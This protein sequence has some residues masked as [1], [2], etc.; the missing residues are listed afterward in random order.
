MFSPAFA[1]SFPISVYHRELMSNAGLVLVVDSILRTELAPRDS[2]MNFT[3][4]VVF[5]EGK[6]VETEYWRKHFVIWEKKNHTIVSIKLTGFLEIVASFKW[7]LDYSL[8]TLG[9]GH[10]KCEIL[11]CSACVFSI[12]QG[13]TISV[14]ICLFEF[15]F[16]LN[17]N[18]NLVVLYSALRIH[19][20][21]N[22]IHFISFDSV[23]FNDVCLFMNV[24]VYLTSVPSVAV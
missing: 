9:A 4:N 18:F 1:S 24:Y 11:F 22:I 3:W 7:P 2:D 8:G 19:S 15:F 12:P 16:F 10:C 20:T 5:T 6:E 13:V 17:S 21:M 23:S 14:R